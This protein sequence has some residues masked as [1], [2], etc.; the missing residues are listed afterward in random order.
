[1][2]VDW[3]PA[4]YGAFRDLRLRPALDLLAQVGELRAGEVVDLGCGDG[5]VGPALVARYPTR[6]LVGVDASEAMLA[7][8][9]LRRCY[10]RVARAD[11]ADWQPDTP[12][13]L[14]FSNA[15]LNWL[16]GHGALMP[17]LAGMLAPGGVLAVQMPR[18]GDAPSHRLL[19][20]VARGLFPGRALPPRSPVLP[21]G[22][23]VELLLPLGDVRAWT[24]DY[25]QMLGPV[26]QGHPVRAFVESTAMRP[27]VEGLTPD[28]TRAFVA[29]YDAALA[30]AYPALPDGR[31]LFP[32]TRVFFILERS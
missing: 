3:D 22:E 13:A 23:Y 5:A 32:F 29:A 26:P 31:V 30:E 10:E 18:Q 11:I 12:P 15:A 27:F 20:E 14:I 1:M 25:L 4:R 17:R 21:A 24:T 16:P 28:E 7:N 2:A 8:A 9:A 19:R 6:C